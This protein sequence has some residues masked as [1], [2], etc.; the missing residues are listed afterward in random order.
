MN[1]LDIVKTEALTEVL[2]LY[3][4]DATFGGGRHEND[5]SIDKKESL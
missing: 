5:K 4:F 2:N 1:K 3:Q